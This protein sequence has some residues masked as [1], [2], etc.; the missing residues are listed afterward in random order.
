MTMMKRTTMKKLFC[1]L[2][3]L[4][5]AVGLLGA[6]PFG[7][8]LGK[9][10]QVSPDV[11]VYVKNNEENPLTED[12]IDMLLEDDNLEDGDAIT[13]IDVVDSPNVDLLEQ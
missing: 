6:T 4:I 1:S 3:A 7:E 13:I 10:Y 9:L 11:S 12:E 8:T 5:L 2:S